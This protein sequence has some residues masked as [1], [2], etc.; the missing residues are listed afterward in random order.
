MCFLYAVIFYSSMFF[1]LTQTLIWF[2]FRDFFYHRHFW[3]AFLYFT[4]FISERLRLILYI[5]WSFSQSLSLNHVLLFT[6]SLRLYIELFVFNYIHHLWF[7]LFKIFHLKIW[8]K[9]FILIFFVIAA[10]HLSLFCKNFKAKDFEMV[11]LYS[12]WDELYIFSNILHS[13]HV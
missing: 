5:H 8:E 12:T 4:T 13:R 11:C 1:F 3:F 2:V 7:L 10:F 9:L 6:T